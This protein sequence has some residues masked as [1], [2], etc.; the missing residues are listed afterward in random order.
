MW[1]APDGT[2]PIPQAAIPQVEVEPEGVPEP[3]PPPLPARPERAPEGAPAVVVAMTCTLRRDQVAPYGGVPAATPWMAALAAQGALFDDAI[4]ASSWTKASATAMFTGQHALEVGM[5]EPGPGQNR[6]VLAD[7][8][9]TLAE[10]LHAAGWDTLG[11][12]ANPN[13]NEAFGLAQGFDRYRDTATRGFAKRNRISGA[14][15]VAAALELVANRDDPE[16]PFYLRVAIID[17]H[18]P[19]RVEREEVEPF[20]ADGTRRRLARYRAGVRQTDDALAVLDAGLAELGWGPERVVWAVVADHGEGLLLPEHHR[21][22][23]GR[24]LYPSTVRVPWLMRGPGIAP[25]RT[26][27]GLASHVDLAPTV[28]GLLGLDAELPGR[29]WS[30]LLQGRGSRTDRRRAWSDT[31]YYGANRASVWTDD[32]QCQR[33]WGSSV[34][35]DTFVH[36]CFDRAADPEFTRTIER[37]ELMAEL[38]QWRADRP[39]TAAGAEADLSEDVRRQLEVLGYADPG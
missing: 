15:A 9:V 11:V 28:L 3:P 39:L 21:A 20:K 1:K 27:G 17:P 10:R 35:R 32:T 4:A 33:D 18:T 23:H 29:D 24:V 12:T 36:G 37:P 5:V 25:G 30:A 6:R 8:H 16:R 34:P 7:E 14:D 19:L 22:Q 26:I 13:L 31:W 38:V 2:D